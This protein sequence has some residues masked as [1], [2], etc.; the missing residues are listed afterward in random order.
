MADK[1]TSSDLPQLIS[2]A[3]ERALQQRKLSDEEIR[4]ILHGPITI[5][6]VAN[7]PA[8]SVSEGKTPL[9]QPAVHEQRLIGF[10]APNIEQLRSELEKG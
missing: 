10:I 3:V 1:I 6:L 5:G 9:A 7:V 2:K 8:V 4:H